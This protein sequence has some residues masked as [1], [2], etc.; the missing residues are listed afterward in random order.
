MTLIY[1][2]RP[3]LRVRIIEKRAREM[4][5]A[6]VTLRLCGGVASKRQRDRR[7]RKWEMR[8]QQ[9]YILG[10]SESSRGREA[11]G[12]EVAASANAVRGEA[13]WQVVTG[14]D[15]ECQRV[16][17]HYVRKGRDGHKTTGAVCLLSRRR[18]LYVW[19]WIMEL[20]GA[21]THILGAC[22]VGSETPLNHAL[23]SFAGSPGAYHDA[24]CSLSSKQQRRTWDP[25]K[26]FR[27]ALTHRAGPHGPHKGGPTRLL[28]RESLQWTLM[29]TIKMWTLLC[30]RRIWSVIHRAASRQRPTLDSSIECRLY[31]RIYRA[32]TRGLS[33]RFD[34]NPFSTKSSVWTRCDLTNAPGRST[35]LSLE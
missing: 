9:G 3:C 10:A 35:S 4:H 5:G 22:R 8:W 2:R 34:D 16:A 28:P 29:A 27:D 13:G 18:K 21:I 23:H 11:L 12:I 20:Y 26:S 19:I 7:W 31:Y 17:R 33:L 32:K 25:I 30:P 1:S 15:S 14:G 6:Q 24:G